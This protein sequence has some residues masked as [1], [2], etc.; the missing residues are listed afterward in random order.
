MTTTAAWEITHSVVTDASPV[1]AWQFWTD[2]ANWD[3]PP[4]RFQL[5][6]PFASGSR[7][8]THLPGQEPLHW[9]IR[10][11][12]P[13]TAA[14]IDLSLDGA[15]LSFEW[16]FVP[17]ADGKTLLTQ[18]IVLTGENANIYVPQVQ[19]AFTA[20]PPHAMNRLALAMANADPN[21]KNPSSD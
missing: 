20:N 6:A 10:D 2:V 21:R 19:V 9:L 3:D 4:A 16:R 13:P 12:T 14:T 17:A 5:D 15:T 1:F 7:G 18:R 8:L 11:V